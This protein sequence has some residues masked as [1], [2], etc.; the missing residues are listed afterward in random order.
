M[1]APASADAETRK[2]AAVQKTVNGGRVHV[3]IVRDILDGEN[4][5]FGQR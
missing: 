3:Q 2:L 4:G 5:G 1:K